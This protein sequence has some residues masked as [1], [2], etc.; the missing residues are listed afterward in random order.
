MR[1]ALSIPFTFGNVLRILAR[2]DFYLK[3]TQ[4]IEKISKIDTVVFDKT[5]TITS[6]NKVTVQYF[7]EPLTT[8]EQYLN[9]K[10]TNN[11]THPLS[12]A[13]TQKW[14]EKVQSFDGKMD[15]LNQFKEVIGKG[16]EADI[17]INQVKV[18]SKKFIDTNLEEGDV[19][20]A[21]N[22]H[23]KGLFYDQAKLPKRI[24]SNS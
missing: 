23:V 19:Y 14:K 12:I 18:G 3:N 2:Q 15:K 1:F 17:G 8:Y 21:I 4:V 9:Y 6:N 24:K 20:V 22:G 10:T 7:G 11:S 5:G 16:I 13:I